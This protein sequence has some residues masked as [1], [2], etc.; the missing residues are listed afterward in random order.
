MTA[1]AFRPHVLDMFEPQDHPNVI[2]YPGAPPTPPYDN[3]GW[4]LAFQMGVAF[5]RVLEPFSGPFER[6]DRLERVAAARPGNDRVRRR[7]VS[8][9]PANQRRVS[10]GEPPAGRARDG[11]RD[12]R[13][14]STS[15]PLP[16][17]ARSCRRSR[18]ISASAP[19]VSPVRSRQ[20]RTCA[21]HE[22]GCGISTAGRSSQDG[23]GGSSS[24]SNSRSNGSSPRRLDAG[25]LNAAYDVLIFPNGGIPAAAAGGRGGRGGGRAGGA[26]P[27]DAAHEIPQE[28]RAQVG[29]VSTDA[30][31]PQL[32]QFIE[33]GGTVIA[34]GDSAVNLAASLKLPVENHLIENGAPLARARYFVPGSVLSARVDITPPHRR[35]HDPRAP[36]SSST[37]ALSSGSAPARRPP[38]FARLPRSTA[39]RRCGA[40]GRGDRNISTAA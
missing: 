25:N 20:R 19:R 15:P 1:Q 13:T 29:R 12:R 27:T 2:P 40:V 3:A 17:P 6:V 24:S 35:R 14:R 36:T 38:A 34:I 4:T 9:R 18:R 16:Q 21:R 28:Y 7:G 22:S 32:R 5:D 26:G 30:T 31:L 33:G 23:R 37:T 10:R 8:H 11:H 39:R